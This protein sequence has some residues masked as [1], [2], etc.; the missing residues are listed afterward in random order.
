MAE[1][2][3]AI[4]RLRR[5]L[6]LEAPVASPDGLGGATHGFEAVAALWAEVEWLSGSES[7]RRGRPEQ[8]RDYRVTIR[9]RGDVDAGRRLRDGDRLFDIRSAADPDG[10]RRRLVCLVEEV[11]P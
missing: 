11:V 3:A 10:S 8:A 2:P 5:R 4:G 7:W 9:W 6:V 1:E